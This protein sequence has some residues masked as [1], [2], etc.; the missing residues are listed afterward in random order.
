MPTPTYV[1]IS[2][3][4]LTSSQSSVVFSGI[5]NTYTDL[6]VLISP[7]NTGAVVSEFFYFTFNNDSSGIYSYT[8]LQGNSSAASSARSVSDPRFIIP[9]GYPGAS[10]T[11]NTFGSIEIYIPNYASS[12]N[13]LASSTAVSENNSS[14][15]NNAYIQTMAGLYR[16]TTAISSI[17]FNAVSGQYASGSRFDLYG[18]K[19]S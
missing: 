2:K 10:A 6:V 8:Q 14:T 16:S 15:A 11:S 9:Y 5:P 12:A 3:N 19:N 7:R 13:K 18:I 1:A 4:V 17:E